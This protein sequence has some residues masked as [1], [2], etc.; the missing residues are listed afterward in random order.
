MHFCGG[1]LAWMKKVINSCKLIVVLHD[2]HHYFNYY[3]KVAFCKVD[4]LKF[5]TMYYIG[6]VS[7]SASCYMGN[8]FNMLEVACCG[9]MID[10]LELL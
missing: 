8:R 6:F 1:Q 10:T 3:R 7:D 5:S 2:I 4:S 9:G